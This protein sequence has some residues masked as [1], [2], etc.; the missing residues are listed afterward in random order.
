MKL[1]A[2]NNTYNSLLTRLPIGSICSVDIHRVYVEHLEPE[3][4]KHME[5]KDYKSHLRTASRYPKTQ[6]A[7][8]KASMKASKSAE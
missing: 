8:I 3:I 2:Y 4:H 5:L 6:M 7:L 1:L